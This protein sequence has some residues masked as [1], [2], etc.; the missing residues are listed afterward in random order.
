MTMQEV[1]STSFGMMQDLISC[2]TIYNGAADQAK[3]KMS[4]DE[5]MRLE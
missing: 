3:R 5:I 2:L 1:K 4:D